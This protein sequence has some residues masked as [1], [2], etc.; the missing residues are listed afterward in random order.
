MALIIGIALVMFL[1]LV[2]HELGHVIAAKLISAPIVSVGFYSKAIPHPHVAIESPTSLSKKAFYLLAGL[3]STLSLL[4]VCYAL[5][6][7]VYPMIYLAFSF[8]IAL[9]TNPYYSD[10]TILGELVKPK[11]KTST[12]WYVHFSIWFIILFYVIKLY[13]S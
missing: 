13:L 12:V 4:L 5:N 1:L 6:L 11:Y 9:E 7:L 2:F 8:Q 3:M 10:L